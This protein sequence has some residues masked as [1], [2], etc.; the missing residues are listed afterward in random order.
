MAAVLSRI[1]I[2]AAFTGL[3]AFQYPAAAK[4]AATKAI[5]D[6]GK[7]L[8][9]TINSTANAVDDAVSSTLAEPKKK[10]K[11]KSATAAKKKPA[12]AAAAEKEPDAGK[13]EA[14]VDSSAGNKAGKNAK[15]SAGPAA[16]RTASKPA[17]GTASKSKAAAATPVKPEVAPG[18]S[19]KNT[20]PE[21]TT[22]PEKAPPATTPPDGKAAPNAAA[23]TAAAPPP[24]P[25]TW[26]DEEVKTARAQC[27]EILKR[28]HAVAIYEPPL[29]SGACGT[30]A[31]IQLIS[32]GQ[33]PEVSISPPALVT[34][35]LAENLAKW[36][37]GDLQPLAQK[38]LGGALIK[39]ENMSAYSCRNAYGRKNT[40]LSE[41]GLANALDIRGFVAASSKT[42]FVLEDW[43]TPQR[44]ILARIAAEKAKAEKLAAERAA[45]EKAAQKN[46]LADQ[47]KPSAIEPPAATASSAGA[48]AGG[49]ARSTVSGGVPR[50]TVTLPGAT[51]NG[52]EDPSRTGLTLTEPAK[53]GGPM[54]VTTS[55]GR[56]AAID[57]QIKIPT[58]KPKPDTRSEAAR[59]FLHQ[60]HD[61]A[62]QIFHTTLGPEANAAHRNHFHVDMAKRRS[63]TTKICD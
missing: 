43:G 2:I 62:C 10:T 18:K 37:E 20:A 21:K 15:A 34:C 1:G 12:T 36:V 59:A 19:V 47:S 29:K 51:D 7:A 3:L 42:A 52:V 57:I 17:T 56:A 9:S 48:P 50:V 26:T 14:A 35:E 44:E 55:A 46:Q 6:V 8:K 28:I 4:D 58:R 60:A 39:I 33:N 23:A 31:P 40:K 30:A 22:A 61:A 45:A 24:P 27:D 41:H 5:E 32:I 25:T 38:H 13:P 63:A 49:V 16:K 53:L 11:R 54:A